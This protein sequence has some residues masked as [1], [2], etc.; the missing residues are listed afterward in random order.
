M[1]DGAS[2]PWAIRTALIA[3]TDVDRSAAFY[4]EVSRLDEI[5]HDGSVAILGDAAP[6][7]FILMLRESRASTRHGQQSLG[8][9]SITFNV[10]STAELDRVETLLREQ[11][12]FTSRREIVEGVSDL[13]FG[14]DP[15]NL[16]LA[17]VSYSAGVAP[18]SDYYRTVA[19]FVYS[20]DT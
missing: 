16:P 13:L 8:L 18:S 2:S 17:F 15:D 20:L 4:T 10:G 3:V 19:D 6:S 5:A 11:D 14:R 12:R 9:R 7:G 1:S